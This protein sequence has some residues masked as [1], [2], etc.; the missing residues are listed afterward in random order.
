M[1]LADEICITVKIWNN[2]YK[3]WKVCLEFSSDQFYQG[4]NNQLNYQMAVHIW[5]E[6]IATNAENI[7]HF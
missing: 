5:Y 6:I 3:I 7:K 2:M 4:M 1:E